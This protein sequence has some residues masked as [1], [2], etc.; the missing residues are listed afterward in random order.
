MGGI[1][2]ILK[3]MIKTGAPLIVMVSLAIVTPWQH[4][5]AAWAQQDQFLDPLYDPAED[6]DADTRPTE[7]PSDTGDVESTTEDSSIDL[8]PPPP[9][10]TSIESEYTVIDAFIDALRFDPRLSQARSRAR[11]A[12]ERVRQSKAILLPNITASLNSGTSQNQVTAQSEGY[13]NTGSITARQSLYAFGRNKHG[14]RAAEASLNSTLWRERVVHALVLAETM[15]AYLEA[16]AADRGYEI[17]YRHEQTS[18][19]LL[20]TAFQRYRSGV[21]QITDYRL[22]RSLFNQAVSDRLQAGIRRS[23]ARNALTRLTGAAPG[24]L[25]LQHFDSLAA[26]APRSLEEALRSARREHPELIANLYV[27]RQSRN[28]AQQARSDV[29]PEISISASL[30]AGTVGDADVG[31]SQLLLVFDSPLYSGGLLQSRRAE[32]LF[33]VAE[34]ERQLDVVRQQIN[35]QV[36]NAWIELSLNVAASAALQNALRSEDLALEELERQA[37]EGVIPIHQVL[38]ARRNALDVVVADARLQLSIP[39][40]RFSLMFA[41]G[42]MNAQRLGLEGLLPESDESQPLIIDR[43]P[44]VIDDDENP[45]QPDAESP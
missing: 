28:L 24:N 18:Y 20:D 41:S 2:F 22:V 12:E 31:S 6:A 38:T 37:D 43:T 33:A 3:R 15:G 39:R 14:I 25:S 13:Q 10:L 17:Y 23:F 42:Q 27:V 16:L 36:R 30:S 5:S 8:P 7:T 26:A 35:E 19:E 1:F 44:L 4:F 29:F 9:P 40:S 21:L 32:R 11:Q 45:T 34:N